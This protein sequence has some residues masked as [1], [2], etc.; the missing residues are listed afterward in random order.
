MANTPL[1]NI[2]IGDDLWQHAKAVAEAREETLTD[3]LRQ[4]LERY[5]AR[6]RDVMPPP[7]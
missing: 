4:A 2:R 6:N 7:S 3:V 1:R 5:V